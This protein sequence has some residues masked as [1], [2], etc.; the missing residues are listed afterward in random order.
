VKAR[1]LI[2]G[3]SF[4]PDV[5]QVVFAAFDDAWMEV[6]PRIGQEP[7]LVEQARLSLATIVLTLSR[8]GPID[9]DNLKT[10]AVDAFRLKHRLTGT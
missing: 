4:P 3:A 1:Q 8:T 5:L 7:A 6:A 9:R 2:G 10:A